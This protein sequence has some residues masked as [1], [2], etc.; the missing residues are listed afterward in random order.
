MSDV[1][2]RGSTESVLTTRDVERVIADSLDVNVLRGKRVLMIIPDHTRTAP[3]DVMFKAIY[4]RLAECVAALDVIVALGTHHALS[5]EQIYRRVGITADEHRQLYTKTQFFNHE[6]DNPKELTSVGALSAEETAELTEGRLSR[7]VE[8][9]INRKALQYDHLLIVG[10]VFPHE[11]VGFSGGNKYLFPG[12]AGE[13]ILNFFHWLGALITNPAVIGHKYTRIRAVVDRAASLV[14]TPK[15]C[16]A[17]VVQGH[18]LAGLYYGTPEEAWS[19]AADLSDKVHICYKAH[20]FHTVL[21]QAPEMYDDIWVGGKCMYK[22]EPVVAEGGTLIIYAPHITEI[23]HT[24]G[25][26]IRQVGYHT[27]DYFV[28]QWDRFKDYPW[29]VIAHSTHV[30]GIGSYENGV[31]KPR[32]NVVLATGISEEVCRQVN[33]GYL[34]PASIATDDYQGREDEGI[35]Y[36]PRAGETLYRLR[37]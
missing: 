30:K 13:E 27:R 34:D 4:S 1:I 7:S 31:E 14:R 10:P 23:S 25:D 16:F 32:V 33:L 17:M 9:R 18:G 15:S 20:P 11:V 29:G 26:L 3:V 28:K 22:L 6:W 24:H 5:M 8:V 21:S 12:I 35:L 2:G 19:A 36:V 37:Q